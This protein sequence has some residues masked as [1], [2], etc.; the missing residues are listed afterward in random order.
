MASNPGDAA[1]A[2]VGEC[3][4]KANCVSVAVGGGVGAGVDF[5]AMKMKTH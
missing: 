5:E 2:V 1:A 3:S 4:G